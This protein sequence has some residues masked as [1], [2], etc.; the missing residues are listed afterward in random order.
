MEQST[1]IK[2]IKVRN[3]I[4]KDE[5]FLRITRLFRDRNCEY[6]LASRLPVTFRGIVEPPCATKDLSAVSDHFP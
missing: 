1:H 4:K 3:I 6:L 2:H 5:A